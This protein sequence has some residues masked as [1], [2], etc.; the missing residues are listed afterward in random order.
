MAATE[1]NGTLKPARTRGQIE[2]IPGRVIEAVL[3]DELPRSTTP[4]PS[5]AATRHPLCEVDRRTRR[6][7]RSS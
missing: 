5:T 1:T 2:E 4:I 6:R 7:P 3:P